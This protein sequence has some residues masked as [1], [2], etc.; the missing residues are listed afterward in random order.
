MFCVDVSP[1][2]LETG[3]AVA[4]FQAVSAA[5]DVVPGADRAR[6][7]FMTFNSSLQ[8]YRFDDEGTVSQIVVAADTEVRGGNGLQQFRG[9]SFFLSEGGRGRKIQRREMIRVCSIYIYI[10]FFHGYACNLHAVI[11]ILD[12]GPRVLR[13]TDPFFVFFIEEEAWGGIEQG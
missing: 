4:C 11:V 8:V 12:Y 2:A 13:R 7:G 6:V 5:L 9:F 3:F 10:F 1:R